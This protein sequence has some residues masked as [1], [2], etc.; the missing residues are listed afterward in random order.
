M[1]VSQTDSREA[2]VQT[3]K[4][5]NT[6]DSVLRTRVETLLKEKRNLQEELDKTQELEK[7]SSKS[8]N[9]LEKEL[10]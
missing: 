2:Q 1:N 9:L 3:E 4:S 10:N 7:K 8:S 5:H 6:D